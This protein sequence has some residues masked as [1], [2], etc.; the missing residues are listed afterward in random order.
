MHHTLIACCLV[1]LIQAC[2]TLR[3]YAESSLSS[4]DAMCV[5]WLENIETV[6]EQY[7]VNDYETVRINEF[8]QLRTN[9][10][11]ASMSDRATSPDAFA[12][13]LEDMRMF[14]AT[15]K[16]LA[17]ANLPAPARRQLVATIPT[18]DSFDKALEYCGK[19]LNKLSLTNAKHKKILLEHSHVPDAY[20]SWKRVV[21]LYPLVKYAA[22]MGIERLHRELN[23]N[24]QVPL[25]KLPQLGR[26]IRYSPLQGKPISPERIA[27]ILGNSYANPLGIPRLTP[28]QL[29]EFLV[30]FA[31]VW[32]VDTRNASDII[33]TVR[34]DGNQ[35]P[36]IDTLQPAVYVSHGYTRWQG[37]VL[38]QLIYQIWFPER[39]KTSRLDFYGGQLDSVIWR[40]T[41]SPEGTPIA[42]DSI[43]ACGCY[44]LLS[45]G[46]GYRVISPKD[47][48]ESVLS[49]KSIARITPGFRLLLRLQSRTH[50]VQHVLLVDDNAETTAQHY[51]FHELDQLRSLPLPN[52]SRQSLYGEGGLVEASARTERFL[53]WPYGIASP[54]AMRQ[55]GTHAIAFI[56]R[57]HFDD[58]FLLENL[59]DEE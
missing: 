22:A 55:W 24:F 41:L 13:W 20:Q 5:R 28:L 32:E 39:E 43:H 12:D 44:Y 47:G 51:V 48:A 35:Q 9:R 31:P 30:Y 15:G 56:G 52:G 58:P 38:L 2:A 42:F 8:P 46:Q 40:V 57:R 54:G 26:L 36:Q 19:R 50:Y 37:K 27:E 18:G 23:A 21:G 7:D 33:G 45:P 10:F 14:D 1:V 16:K 17:F 4:E 3:P 34:L 29:Q 11:M 53:L 25:G 49:P 59:L 6:L